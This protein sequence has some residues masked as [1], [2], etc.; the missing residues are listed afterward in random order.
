MAINQV[1]TFHLGETEYGLCI[2]GVQEIRVWS[3]VTRL[4]EVPGHILG[5]LNLRGAVVPIIDL[6]MRFGKPNPTLTSLTVIIVLSIGEGHHR[7]DCGLVVDGVSDVIDLPAEALR[8][9]PQLR[10]SPASQYVEGIATIDK[11][12]LIMLSMD[13]LVD[14]ELLSTKSHP[15]SGRAAAA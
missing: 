13:R 9:A 4:P 10:D 15:R 3:P 7:R 14:Q 6:R 12:I 5:V 1:L 2:H 8:A 11:R